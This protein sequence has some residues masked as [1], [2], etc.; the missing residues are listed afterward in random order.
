VNPPLVTENAGIFRFRWEDEAIDARV[1]KIHQTRDTTFAEWR[2]VSTFMGGSTLIFHNNVNMLS[3]QVKSSTIK[4]C[5]ERSS[6]V[7]WVQIVETICEAVLERTRQGEPARVLA[8][9]VIPEG[10]DWRLYPF[11]T[12]G[13][14]TVLFAYGG[15]VAGETLLQG[16]DGEERFDVL[17]ARGLPTAIWVIGAKGIETITVDAPYLKGVARLFRVILTNGSQITVTAEHRFLTERGWIRAC[18]A[19]I[20][21]GIAASSRASLAISDGE[22]SPDPQ[23]KDCAD[24][25]VV[26]PPNGAHWSRTE[27]DSQGHYSRD[28]RLSDVPLPWALGSGQVSFP[29]RAGAPSRSLSSLHEDAPKSLHTRNQ[30]PS[31][32]GRPSKSSCAQGGPL[33]AGG[34]C[35][36]P[37]SNAEEQISSPQQQQQS[38]PCCAAQP[39]PKLS[40]ADVQTLSSAAYQSAFGTSRGLCYFSSISSI[41][42]I[43]ADYY[44]DIS[45]PG[46]ENYLAN[47]MWHHNSLKS[48]LS[49]MCAI[50]VALGIDA[51]PGNV[52][53]LDWESNEINWRRRLSMVSQGMGVAEPTNVWHRYC[54]QPL[55]NE[56][57]AI[58]RIGMDNEIDFYILDSAAYACGGEPEKAD[59]T[60]EFFRAIRALHR[61]ALVIA[62]QRDDDK[63]TRPFGSVYWRD[64]P[65]STIQVRKDEEHIVSHNGVVDVEIAL[66]N[67]K[68]NNGRPFKPF[69]YRVSFFQHTEDHYTPGDWVEFTRADVSTNPQIASGF[70]VADRISGI[71]RHGR[72]R[73]STIATELDIPENVIRATLSRMQKQKL[74][75]KLG[76]DWGLAAGTFGYPEYSET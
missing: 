25:P 16:P 43:G 11:L 66:Y 40:E 22:G 1:E 21:E 74:V 76:D 10:M 33:L 27:Q 50:R 51:E 14:T 62:H 32:S 54:A 36:E 34:G 60:M 70:S 48:Y 37:S 15:C 24:A 9:V 2:I 28:S 67:R 30:Q 35:C 19:R 47:G 53:V 56:I 29:S 75:E 7:D 18:D 20:G 26:S 64:S 41:T 12:E 71:L 69:G 63:S 46:Y 4:V 13:E 44:Y 23:R 72:I 57:E 17:A 42:E 65:R 58:Q 3:A 8:D 49:C 68:V 61:T 31:L 38:P 6:E 5:R 55:T 45:V 73:V 59:P 39:S 52:L